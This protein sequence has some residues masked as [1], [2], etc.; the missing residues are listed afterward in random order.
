[1][2]WFLVWFRMRLAFRLFV[3]AAATSITFAQ[4]CSKSKPC[5]T[6]AC[7]S[8]WGN[9]GY[10]PDFC[11][12]GCQNNC[13]AKPECGKWSKNFDC[14]LRVC[15]SKWGF[16]G[17]TEDFCNKE[18]Q[19]NCE[20]PPE[21]SCSSAVRSAPKVN[22]GY[23]ASWA[24]TRKCEQFTIDYIEPNLYTHLNYAFVDIE[25]GVIAQ[26]SATES[27]NLHNFAALKEIN[28]DLKV[29]I[30]VGGWAFNDP[31]PRQTEFSTLAKTRD[32]RKKFIDS[33]LRFLEEYD[34]DGIDIDWE[35]IFKIIFIFVRTS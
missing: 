25:N 30:S 28:R 19:G 3:V 7:C 33:V 34:F 14:P 4:Q 22:I 1:M 9:C 10:G 29:L 5:D 8:Q 23:Y 18:C 6:D 17:T 13:D 35:V 15:C 26:L 32:S 2:E 16:C 24:A 11:G 12:S 27:Q 21:P 20:Q 31:G